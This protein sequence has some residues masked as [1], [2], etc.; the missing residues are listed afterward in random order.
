[1]NPAGKVRCHIR[2][3]IELAAVIATHPNQPHGHDPGGS[4]AYAIRALPK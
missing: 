3:Q 4:G 2:K 1:M